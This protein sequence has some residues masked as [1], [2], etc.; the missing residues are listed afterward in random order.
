MTHVSEYRGTVPGDLKLSPTVLNAIM[1][2]V[3]LSDVS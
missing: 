3:F 2:D 1:Y